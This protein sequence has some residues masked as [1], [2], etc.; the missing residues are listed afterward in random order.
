MSNG[1]NIV[2]KKFDTPADMASKLLQEFGTPFDEV[3]DVMSKFDMDKDGNFKPGENSILVNDINQTEEMKQAREDRLALKRVRVKIEKKR[4]EL[5]KE[6]LRT[7]QIID[8]AAKYLKEQIE[9]A[10]KYLELQEKFAEVKR[11]EELAKKRAERIEKIIGLGANPDSYNLDVMTDETFDS[12]VSGI[13][14]SNR[15]KAEAEKAELERLEKE[16]VE[17]EAEE[18]RIREENAR[19]RAEAE[20]KEIQLAKERKQREAI[21]LE[22]KKKDE[23]EARAKAEAEEA[24]RQALLAPDKDKLT[25]FADELSMIR[26]SKLPAVSSNNAQ[27]VVNMIDQSLKELESNIIKLSNNLQEIN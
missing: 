1:L 9:P 25:K 5:K 18:K 13:I 14:E 12:T 20:A 17:K 6:S 23:A 3:N 4:V 22:A 15:L 10:E 26:T 27:R 21:E 7:T 8:G 24:E 11:A 16:R 19:L 2:L